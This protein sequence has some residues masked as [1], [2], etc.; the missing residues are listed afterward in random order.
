MPDQLPDL[1]AEPGEIIAQP[2]PEPMEDHW[3]VVAWDSKNKWWVMLNGDFFTKRWA[4]QM[5]G[6]QLAKRYT[7]Y[8]IVRIPGDSKG[9]ET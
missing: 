5:R 3:I 8:R 7:H 2:M 1:T 4:A 9:G 6:S